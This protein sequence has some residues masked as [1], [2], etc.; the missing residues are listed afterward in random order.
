M[1]VF[2]ITFLPKQSAQVPVLA[3]NVT[4]DCRDERP[5]KD[6]LLVLSVP[7]GQGGQMRIIARPQPR[8]TSGS[9]TS[10]ADTPPTRNSALSS[11]SAAAA[12]AASTVTNSA[13]ISLSS[14]L[15]AA[16]AT[17]AAAASPTEQLRQT[18]RKERSYI[19]STLQLEE[20]GLQ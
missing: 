1:R 11:T 10:A 14:P 8:G 2:T 19:L 7:K 5:C 16:N 6:I 9:F 17:A 15:A 13:Y 4:L 18:H 3:K 20:D 12:A